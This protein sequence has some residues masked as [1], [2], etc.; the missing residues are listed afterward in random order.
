[1]IKII[2]LVFLVIQAV[3]TIADLWLLHSQS[4]SRSGSI[5]RQNFG[6]IGIFVLFWLV[7]F[8]VQ[9]G[10]T[11][12]LPT[13]DSVSAWICKLA[14]IDPSSPSPVG[15]VAWLEVV[16][17]ILWSLIWISFWD[18]V[19]HRL[20]LHHNWGFK[21]H[22]YHHFP[23]LVF[24]GMPGISVRPFVFVATFL[25]YIGVLPLLYLPLRYVTSPEVGAEFFAAFPFWSW[26]SH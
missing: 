15:A 2:V 25:T 5:L 19:T 24:N 23:R 1:M 17:L 7:F 3:F 8:A 22:E 11:L 16:A 10:G 4:R 6:A 14:H 26:R 12:I 13:F 20:V 21:F 9:T 18:Y